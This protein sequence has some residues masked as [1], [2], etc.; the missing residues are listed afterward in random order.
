M[1]AVLCALLA[2]V[3]VCP[4]MLATTLIAR[5][6]GWAGRQW[7]S[8]T[9]RYY[10]SHDTIRLTS[11]YSIYPPAEVHEHGWAGFDLSP[12]PESAT[13]VD[14]RFRFFLYETTY[15]PPGCLLRVMD[16]VSPNAESLYNLILAGLPAS[17]GIGTGFGWNELALD[18]GG[19]AALQPCLAAGVVDIGIECIGNWGDGVFYG[20]AAPDSLKPRLVLDYSVGIADAAGASPPWLVHLSPI[21]C[22]GRLEVSVSGSIKTDGVWSV[23]DATGRVVR[24]GSL[25]GG[26]SRLV[27][28]LG[29]E[30]VGVY[31]I[32]L[33][34]QGFRCRGR[35]VKL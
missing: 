25:P 31:T 34:A 23:R 2:S 33:D 12:L 6:S 11:Y 18:A 21:P 27:I 7:M 14:A 9:T 35:V 15:A 16:H 17:D 5:N 24:R 30:P 1:V 3:P 13:I 22:R 29:S 20:T 4:E 8:D 19:R 28:D 32:Q 10:S 26:T